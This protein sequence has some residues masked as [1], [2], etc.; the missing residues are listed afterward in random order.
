MTFKKKIK[1]LRKAREEN[2][3]VIF[4]GAGVS[5]NSDIPTWSELIKCFAEKLNYSN[6]KKCNYRKSDCP[7]PDCNDRYNF[8]QDEY[9]KIPQYFFNKDTSEGKSNYYEIIKQV[10]NVEVKPNPIDE[11][12]MDLYPKHIITTNFDKLIENTKRPNSM[13]YKVITKDEELL[14]H[15]ANNNYIIKMHGDIDD[16]G[17]IVLKESDYL[18]YH[19]NHILIETFIKSLLIDH[20]FLFIGY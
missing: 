6:C 12:I 7:I 18:K 3:L 17:T 16:P 14:I 1:E 11:M 20:T 13:M 4:V 10:L 15:Q 19:Q 5:K 9:L 2:R 8:C